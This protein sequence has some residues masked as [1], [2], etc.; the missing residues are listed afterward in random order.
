MSEKD[1]TKS[2]KTWVEENPLLAL[3]I[4]FVIIDMLLRG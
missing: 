2:M 1:F 3:I 4:G